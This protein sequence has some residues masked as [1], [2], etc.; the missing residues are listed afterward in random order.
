MSFCRVD[1]RCADVGRFLSMNSIIGKG[2]GIG[3]REAND[4]KNNCSTFCADDEDIGQLGSFDMCWLVWKIRRDSQTTT[5][6]AGLIGIYSLAKFKL[7]FSFSVDTA[8]LYIVCLCFV[9]LC[10]FFGC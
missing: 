6:S 4:G 10:F 7:C 1:F 9:V 2:R 8:L 3:G 5:E